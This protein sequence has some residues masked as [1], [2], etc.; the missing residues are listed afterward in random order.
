[1]SEPQTGPL[2][3]DSQVE[4][5]DGEID[6]LVL[7]LALLP[8]AAVAECRRRTGGLK[9]SSYGEGKEE[10]WGFEGLEERYKGAVGSL[11]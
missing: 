7:L 9:I 10:V 6:G 8:C 4:L 1:M 3:G 5:L 11:W 2:D